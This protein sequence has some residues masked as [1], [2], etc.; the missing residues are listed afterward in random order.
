MMEADFI[1]FATANL[2]GTFE[3]FD[4][5]SYLVDEVHFVWYSTYY[6]YSTC[7]SGNVKVYFANS[8]FHSWT[9]NPGGVNDRIFRSF[10][11]TQF[12]ATSYM[13]KCFWVF[14]NI[15]ELIM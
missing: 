6:N 15:N 3:D 2:T 4:D 5:N 12:I 10:L 13:Y 14:L 8:F 11:V 7:I 9:L 1:E